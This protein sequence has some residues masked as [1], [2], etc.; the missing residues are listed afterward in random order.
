MVVPRIYVTGGLV[1]QP[2]RRDRYGALQQPAQGVPVGYPGQEKLQQDEQ[3]Q[4][5]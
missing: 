1:P 4:A 5:A 2:R 3:G